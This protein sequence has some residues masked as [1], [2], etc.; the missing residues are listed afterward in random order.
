M[1]FSLFNILNIKLDK[2]SYYCGDALGRKRDFSDTDLK[3]ALNCNFKFSTPEK[4]FN[5]K[6][7]K[8]NLTISYPALDYYTKNDFNKI[9]F[10]N[11]PRGRDWHSPINNH[12]DQPF[13]AFNDVLSEL[14]V[15]LPDYSKADRNV[16]L[17][18]GAAEG[19]QRALLN[20]PS[21]RKASQATGSASPSTDM[22]LLVEALRS[23][24]PRSL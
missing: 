4:F 21:L 24:A 2:N 6:V 3:F 17:K 8:Q 19:L 9:I 16:F 22:D 23:I 20:V 13:R 1:S 15:H 18:V 14:Q 11:Y 7:P 12:C 5:I 10:D